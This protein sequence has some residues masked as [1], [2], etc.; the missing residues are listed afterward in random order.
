VPNR[1]GLQTNNPGFPGFSSGGWLM[2]GS[3]N[4]TILY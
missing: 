4:L 3:I 2:G 1:E